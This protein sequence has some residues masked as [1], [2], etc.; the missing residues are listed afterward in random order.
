MFEDQ[1]LGVL[2]LYRATP[3]GP[4]DADD[5]DFTLAV[6]RQLGAVWHR[7]RKQA[8][9]LLK[10]YRSGDPAAV[11]WIT[12]HE[13]AQTVSEEAARFPSSD[14]SVIGAVRRLANSVTRSIQ[15]HS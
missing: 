7:L 1:F 3:I 2:H 8:K 11:A 4:L 6:A 5:L 15:R 14:P 12:W 9:G 13:L 10:S